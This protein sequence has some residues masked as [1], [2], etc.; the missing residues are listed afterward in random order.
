MN[1]EKNKKTLRLITI[2][3]IYCKMIPRFKSILGWPELKCVFS[4][5]GSIEKFQN[6]ISSFFNVEDLY[7][8]SLWKECSLDFF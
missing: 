3:Q 1:Y 7:N 6:K 2:L 5:K 8:I 4:K